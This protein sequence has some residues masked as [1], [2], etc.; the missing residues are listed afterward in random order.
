M[1]TCQTDLLLDEIV[2]VEQPDFCRSNPL[3]RPGCGCH[4]VIRR[5]QNTRIVRQPGQ[6]PVRPRTRIDAMLSSQ[7]Y[8]VALQLLDA[9]QLRAQ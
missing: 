1:P 7:R 9:E 8:R 2:I 6:Q 5:Q 3:S 4:D